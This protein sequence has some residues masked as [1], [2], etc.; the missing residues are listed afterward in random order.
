[1]K[2]TSGELDPQIKIWKYKDQEILKKYGKRIAMSPPSNPLK[3]SGSV[4]EDPR[5]FFRNPQ[6][7]KN[8][9]ILISKTA[10]NL[11]PSKN[12]T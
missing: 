5:Y 12:T 9:F 4:I 1:M 10:K 6:T 7:A 8:L 11:S 2:Y 3:S